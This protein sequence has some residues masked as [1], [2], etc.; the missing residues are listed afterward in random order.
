M[1]IKVNNNNNNNK[2]QQGFLLKVKQ[3]ELIL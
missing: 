3:K 2:A 1:L